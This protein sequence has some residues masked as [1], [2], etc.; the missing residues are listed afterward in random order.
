M[1]KF[2]TD[3]VIPE[4]FDFAQDRL[5]REPSGWGKPRDRREG[6]RLS[7]RDVS[8]SNLRLFRERFRDV[9]RPSHKATAWQAIPFDMTS[10]ARASFEPLI[11]C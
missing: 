7:E 5:R 3:F 9:S 10:W 4:P 8:E 1:T 11:R 6:R 2:S